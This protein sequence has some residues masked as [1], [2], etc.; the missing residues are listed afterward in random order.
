M[1]HLFHHTEERVA[2][3]VRRGYQPSYS[4]VLVNKWSL[5]EESVTSN[6]LDAAHDRPLHRFHYRLYQTSSKQYTIQNVP[7]LTWRRLAHS[8]D[9]AEQQSHQAYLCLSEAF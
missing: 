2:T 7:P 3:P 5:A 8:I 9:A 1:L 4:L 6:R